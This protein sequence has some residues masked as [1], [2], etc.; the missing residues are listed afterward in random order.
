MTVP[1]MT[2]GKL[3]AARQQLRTAI[4]MWF[5][6][7]DPI[8]TNTLACAA[9]EILHAVSKKRNPGR[10]K[11]LFNSGLIKEESRKL[12]N[13]GLRRHANFFKHGDRD[14]DAAIPFNPALTQYFFTLAIAAFEECDEPLSDEFSIFKGWLQIQNPDALA[15]SKPARKQIEELFSVN[16]VDHFRRMSKQEFFQ[17]AM[18]E[19]G[20]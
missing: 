4:T 11:L 8:S 7:A 13:D 10:R 3:D 17:L 14:P 20:I 6:D 15:L 2:I 12:V 16:E 9:Y 18:Q 5:H 19:S 1:V